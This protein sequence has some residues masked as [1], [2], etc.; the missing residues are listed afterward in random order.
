MWLRLIRLTNDPNVFLELFSEA[1]YV[2][3]LNSNL[4]S[5]KMMEFK[6]K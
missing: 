2:F 1:P 6:E 4:Q 5:E 3:N